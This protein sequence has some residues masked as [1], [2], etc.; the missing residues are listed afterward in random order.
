MSPGAPRSANNPDLGSLAQ[1]AAIVPEL[2]PQRLIEMFEVMAELD[3]HC[4]RFA[5]RRMTDEERKELIRVHRA[6]EA[7]RDSQ[8]PDD[9]YHKNEVFHRTIYAGSHNSFLADQAM[10]LHRRLS[11]YRRLQL[12]VRDRINNSFSEHETIV[13]AITAGDEELTV[14]RMRDHV[15]IQ[16]QRFADLV[17]S[18]NYAK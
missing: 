14:R 5:A 17:A 1:R 4:G 2:S 7:A 13:T 11:P 10:A 9:Y 18:L 6:C 8:D 12:R 16:G 3:A 15:Q